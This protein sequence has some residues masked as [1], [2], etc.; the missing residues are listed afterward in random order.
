MAL[1]PDTLEELRRSVDVAAPEIRSS[2]DMRYAG[3]NYELEVQLPAGELLFSTEIL[4]NQLSKRVVVCV[5]VAG[6]DVIAE[7][8]TVEHIYDY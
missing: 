7:G 4:T 1:G 8:L 2:A 3:Q 5:P 6:L